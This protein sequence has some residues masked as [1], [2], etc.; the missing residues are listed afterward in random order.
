[1]RHAQVV[2]SEETLPFNVRGI[3]KGVCARFGGAV[4]D[5]NAVRVL[6]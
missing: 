4:E 6:K 5:G 2:P 1:L 3:Q